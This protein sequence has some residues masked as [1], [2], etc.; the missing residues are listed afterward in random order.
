MRKNEST[1]IILFVVSLSII[2]IACSLIP[3]NLESGTVLL[4]DDF[5]NT[6]AKWKI[7]SKTGESAVSIID[8]NLTMI[9]QKPNT[10]IITTNYITHP[11]VYIEVDAFKDFGSNDNLIG[12]VCRYQNDQ[13]YYAFVLSSDGYYGIVKKKLG[14]TELLD[15]QKMKFSEIINQGKEI[16]HLSAICNENSLQFFINGYEMMSVVDND[17]KNGQNGLLI[18]SFADPED[19][20]VS[21]DNFLLIKP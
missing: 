6:N 18:G 7:W 21:F 5:S 1:P 14:K 10:D 11:D 15:S 4:R 16:N 19:L 9:L 3:Q 17:F 20:V 2:L 8:G 12:V 13:N